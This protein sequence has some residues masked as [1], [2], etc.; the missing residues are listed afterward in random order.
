[1]AR[2]GP[3]KPAD[4]GDWEG[5]LRNARDF[6]R[7][8]EELN[9]LRDDDE[10]ANGVIT[11]IVNA[12]IAYADALTGKYGGFFNQQD[13]KT[14]SSAVERALGLRAD[15]AQLKRLSAIIS[16]KDPSSYGVR[17]SRKETSAELLK[18]LE[19]FSDW[20]EHTLSG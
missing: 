2:Q 20:V 1:M 4:P 5:R 3:S 13:H 6:K 15:P 14:V 19:R 10:N 12:A 7:D 17:R 8:A 18:Q 16:Q 11:L 9:D